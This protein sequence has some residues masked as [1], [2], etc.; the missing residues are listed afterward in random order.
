MKS[1]IHK[2]KLETMRK[3]FLFLAVLAFGLTFTSCYGQ[4]NSN[5]QVVD[6]TISKIEVFDF[7]ST[8]RCK[9]CNAIEANTLYTVNT[10]FSEELKAG[11]VTVQ[12]V[13]V[14]EKE[15][16]AIAEKFEA[17]GTALFLNVIKSGKE[18]QI[19]LTDFAF[20]NGNNQAKFSEKL[21]AKIETQLKSL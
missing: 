19:N 1:K 12:V 3:T 16:K 5:D 13:N 4:N 17:F 21:K 15:N 8:H 6:Q 7:H 2:L 10:Y 14:D 18:T 20:L 11:K 9:T